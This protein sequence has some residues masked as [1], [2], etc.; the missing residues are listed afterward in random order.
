MVAMALILLPL[1]TKVYQN[2]LNHNK[3]IHFDHHI[4]LRINNLINLSLERLLPVDLIL[5]TTRFR[6]FATD[7]YV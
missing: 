3:P 5:K 2:P 6:T 4:L 1:L 7:T